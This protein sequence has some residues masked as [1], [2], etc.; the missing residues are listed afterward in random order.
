MTANHRLGHIHVAA[1]CCGLLAW[2]KR[3]SNL[4]HAIMG[5]AR[6]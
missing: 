5:D 1:H 2:G 3:T 4:S 6:K